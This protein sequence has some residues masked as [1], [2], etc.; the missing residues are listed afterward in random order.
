MNSAWIHHCETIARM[1]ADMLAAARNGDWGPVAKLE[2]ARAV[3]IRK[4]RLAASA[5]RPDPEA[6]R[7]KSRLMQRILVNDAEIRQLA[8][9]RLD[10]LARIEQLPS[11]PSRM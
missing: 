4:L 2:G 10:D 9:R 11:H 7:L 3:L 1:N 5:L 6:C 8:E